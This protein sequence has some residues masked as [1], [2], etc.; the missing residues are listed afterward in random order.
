MA[1]WLGIIDYCPKMLTV[2]FTAL[3]YQKLARIAAQ[4]V[5]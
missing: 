5:L 4:Y 1:D 3:S 2:Y